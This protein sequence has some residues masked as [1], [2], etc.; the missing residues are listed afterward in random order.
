MARLTQ[1]R[2]QP[3]MVT[4]AFI[5]LSALITISMIGMPAV[6]ALD[7]ETLGDHTVE[8]ISVEYDPAGY[9]EETSKWTYNVTATTG[10]AKGISHWIIFWCGGEDS[11][12]DS[13]W[14][15]WSYGTDPTTGMRG[16]KFDDLSE[17]EDFQGETRTFWIVL[18]KHYASG[19]TQV[20]IKDGAGSYTGSVTGPVFTYELDLSAIKMERGDSIPEGYNDWQ[21]IANATTDYDLI[22][23]VTFYWS[24]PFTEDE[25]PD[26]SRLQ[27]IDIDAE[28]SDGFISYYPGLSEFYSD[29]DLGWWYV[30]AVF[31]GGYH[32]GEADGTVDPIAT[33]WFTS[34]PLTLLA[35]IGVL[36]LK[37][38]SHR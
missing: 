37:K 34:L 20:A 30:R 15:P 14:D 10:K 38:R 28:G 9:S 3:T 25:T 29:A 21:M 23:T 33:P 36:H 31:T 27:L 32:P 26:E 22:N 17:T 19:Q 4:L 7:I 5:L 1:I 6:L 11:V 13:S 24:G 8:L 2:N 35:A 12:I 18:N 16:I